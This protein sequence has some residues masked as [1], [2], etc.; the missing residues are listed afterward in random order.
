MSTSPF[1][2]PPIFQTGEAMRA[3]VDFWRGE[4]PL[5]RAFWIWGIVGG[6]IVSLALTLVALVTL[7]AGAPGWLTVV[8]FAAHIPWNLV[9]LVGVWRSSERAE[10]R[11]D[12]AQIARLSIVV[13]VIV[14]T[15]F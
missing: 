1:H 13:W 3:L 6:G 4:V 9:L 7:T 14:L 12:L 11:S 10:V 8:I 5:S 15:L 2:R